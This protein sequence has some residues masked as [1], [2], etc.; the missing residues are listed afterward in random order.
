NKLWVRPLESEQAR[1]IEG[2]AGAAGPFW[3]PD[4]RQI[5]FVSDSQLKKVAL[6]GGSPFPLA[7]VGGG[8]RGAS[9]SPDRGTILDSLVRQ[10]LPEIAAGG[11]SLKVVA[12]QSGGTYYW[13]SHLTLAGP[14]RLA[15]AGKGTRST[16]TL[17]LVD[18]D[19]GKSETLRTPG[20]YPVWSP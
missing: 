6:G 4:S 5:G 7:E 10:G 14:R 20:A 11:G 17:V 3:S 2:T 16:Q 15:V 1:P 12:P 9:W 8:Y 18:L 19:T 13:P